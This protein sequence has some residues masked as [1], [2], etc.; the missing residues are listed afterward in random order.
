MTLNISLLKVA[1]LFI[2]WG[3]FWGLVGVGLTVPFVLFL[4]GSILYLFA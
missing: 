3:F 1:V 4:I 2:L